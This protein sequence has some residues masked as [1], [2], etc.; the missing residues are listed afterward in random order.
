MFESFI[1]MF[2][3]KSFYKKYLWVLLFVTLANLFMN[4]SGIYAPILN[5]GK[6]SVWYYL[7]YL[8]GFIIMF[9]PFG[10]SITA[11]RH[12][13]ESSEN[14]ELPNIDILHNFIDG[15]KVILSGAVLMVG[16][17]IIFSVIGFMNAIFMGMSGLVGDILSSVVFAVSLLI[18]FFMSIFGIAMCCRYVKKPGY[19][20][21]VNFKAAIDIINNNAVRYF[22]AYFK[23]FLT[24][25]VVYGIAILLVSFLVKMGYAGLVIYSIAVSVIWTYVIFVLAKIFAKAVDAEKI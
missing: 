12:T 3:D 23:T 11:L 9:V 15:L 13:M 22:K 1:Y 7:L 8:I 24:A 2:K 18:L 21:F 6:T 19:L 17:F 16:L 20:N 25:V 10:Y 4:W 5:N 14:Y